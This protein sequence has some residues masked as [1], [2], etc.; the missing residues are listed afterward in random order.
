METGSVITELEKR[1][2]SKRFEHVL[3]VTE[4]AKKL[5]LRHGVSVDRAEQ[6]ALFHD[7]AK[8]MEPAAMRKLLEKNEE[9]RMLLSFHHELWHAAAGRI[10]AMEEFGVTDP[11]ILN[12]IRFHTT[13]RAG[14]STLEKLIYI[15]DLIEPGRNFPGI[16]ELRE[17]AEQ[18]IDVAMKDCIVH[19]VLYLIDRRAP[20][21]PDSIECYNEHV[22]R[23]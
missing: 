23:K 22:Q 5:A 14:M 18:G 1:L 17:A 10:I 20:V 21:F 8:F 16:E 11:D 2:P 3:R 4:T 7:I 15:A 13:G 12:A 6:A 9:D 19:S